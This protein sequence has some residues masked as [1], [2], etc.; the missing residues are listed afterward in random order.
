MW[1]RKA[2][3]CRLSLVLS[4]PKC[5]LQMV[6][7]YPYFGEFQQAWPVT[8]MLGM[9]LANRAAKYKRD[10]ESSDNEDLEPQPQRSSGRPRNVSSIFR[11]NFIENKTPS[12][13]RMH[14]PM[15]TKRAVKN[16]SQSWRRL[17]GVHQ[18][19]KKRHR[20]YKQRSQSRPQKVSLYLFFFHFL[21]P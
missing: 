2:C 3:E 21:D 11:V 16:R 15:M 18:L 6:K 4:H 20:A 9:I 12:L 17:Q 5:F 10:A 14:L 8:D 7:T 13:H 1:I 19:R